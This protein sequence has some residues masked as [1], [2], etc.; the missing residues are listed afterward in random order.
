MVAPDTRVL[1]PGDPVDPDGWHLRSATLADVDGVH[2]LAC[3]P[4]VYRYLFDG[5]APERDSIAA[6][7]ARAIAD[8]ARTR[9]G[10]WILQCPRAPYGGCVQLRPD[11]S[12]KSAE[13]I[14]FL[15]PAHWGRGLA[16]R[17]GWTA[18]SR[19]FQ[20]P[21]DVV[22]AGTDGANAASLAVMRRLGMRF[23]R[24]VRYPLG[25][26]FEYTLARGDAAPKS[27]PALLAIRREDPP[28]PAPRRSRS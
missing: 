13:L 18:I 12:A 9:L 1:A 3:E 20:G 27:Q 11:L 19:A 7:I 6:E 22:V 14:Y 8:A 25:E 21:F 15:D 2:R 16:T 24:A 4:L 26:G 17:M 5:T 23:H 28:A 10:L